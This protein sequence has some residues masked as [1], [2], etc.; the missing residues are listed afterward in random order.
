MVQSY[1]PGKLLLLGM[2]LTLLLCLPSPTPPLVHAQPPTAP[3]V[4]YN[5]VLQTISIGSNSGAPTASQAIDLPTLDATLTGQG[6]PDLIVD[7]GAGV[8]RLNANVVISATARLEV[9]NATLTE[10]RLDSPPTTAYTIIA[11]RGGHLLLDGIT[12]AAW[13]GDAPDDNITNQ[14]SYLVA[15]EGGRI[16]ILNSDVGYLGWKAGEASG[17]SWRKRLNFNDITTGATG[18]IENSTIHHNYFGMYSYEAYGIKILNSTFRDNISYGIDPHD[19]SYEFEVAHNEVYNNGNHGIIFSRLCERNII[20]HNRVHDNA[21]HGIMLDRGSNNNQIYE[22][23]VYNNGDGIAIFQS[24]NNIIRYNILRNNRR[25]IRINATFDVDD[26]Y[27]GI[28]T[29]NEF[30]NNI[31]ENSQE[32]GVY[33][34]ARADRN[35]I[36]DNWIVGSGVNGI[37]IKSGGNLIQN[38]QI[39][40]GTVGINIRGGEYLDLPPQAAP[41][42]DPPGDN[43]VVISTTIASNS[44]TGIRIS[45][46]KNNRIGSTDASV[47]AN[48]IE[49]NGTDGIVIN[50]VISGTQITTATDN[51]IL[52]NII[53]QN[54][55]HGVSVKAASSARNRISQNSITG[56]GQAGIRLDTDAQGG[57]QP[58]VISAIQANG[59]ASGTAQPN[60]TVELYSDPAGEGETYYGAAIA[61]GSGQ[62]SFTLPGDAVPARVTA[63]AIDGNGNTSEFSGSPVNAAYVIG[64]DIH[65][66]TTITVTNSGAIVTLPM[67]Q[68]GIEPTRTGLLADLGGGVWLLNANLFIDTGVTLNIGPASGVNELR[69]RS[70]ALVH[71]AG[72]LALQAITEP[73][74]TQQVLAIDYGSFV[75]LITHNGTIN[76]EGVKIYSWDPAADTFDTDVSNGRAYILAKYAAVLNIRNSDIGYLGSADG[77]SYG[78]SWRDVNALN[79]PSGTH[80]TRVTGEVI[81][82]KI[83]HNYY[84]IYTFQASNMLFQGNEFYQNIR[85]GFDPHDYTHDVWVE[86]NVAYGN[87]SHGFIISRGCNNF[88]FRNNTS[89]NNFD[90]GTSLAHGFMLDPGS[91]NSDTPQAASY[92]NL[93]ENNVAYGNEGYGI[94]ILGS[95]NNEVRN[96]HFYQNQQGIVVD[97]GSP[98]NLISQNTLDQNTAYGLVLRETADRTTVT[99]NII[100]DNK[101]HGIYVR[102]VNNLITGN[103]VNANLAAG[104]AVAINTGIT[105]SIP[106]AMDNQ[107]LSNTISSNAINGL[108]LRGALRTL[109]QGNQIELNQGAGVYVANSSKQ[110]SLVGNTIHGNKNYG[111]WASGGQTLGNSWS[112]NQIFDNLPAGISLT[113]GANGNIPAPQLLN[114]TGNTVTGLA[115]PNV[116]VELFA[117][118][119]TQGRF[120]LGRTA[121]AVDGTFAFTLT[122]PF[123]APNV[124]ALAINADGNAF[125]V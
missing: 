77:E 44:D 108:D 58:P 76:L 67:I 54:G 6:Y 2:L 94:R 102:S 3:T 49:R 99:G 116:T 114:L 22:N 97:V 109:A 125:G 39:L 66:N 59:T 40:S 121:A 79:T 19:Y 110:N 112:E 98:D 38:N 119:G 63:L 55:R 103:T 120:F 75:S 21:L 41:A 7:Q 32:H 8:W 28:S 34:Y 16:D 42:L 123:L 61:N 89:Y 90:P 71:A 101:N 106:M 100:L 84:G 5:P 26:R 20:H 4:T 43:N 107:I 64:P 80:R 92:D 56:N 30:R 24:S 91:P 23:L 14:R 69:L 117:D 87:G 124:T 51:Q 18:R 62:W 12:L 25:G 96:N 9:T 47:A 93:L 37:Y 81:N 115:S 1:N 105:Q 53:R 72:T 31:V 11:K 74:G 111:I 118:N 33:L 78:I 46:G 10:L 52:R 82:S 36:A 50:Q 45:G 65:G 104:I 88:T 83:H 86:N 29:G 57:I 70:E 17:L 48:R 113:T 13:E 60:A 27:D 95:T 15:L 85:Y 122:T 35:T 73:D 68:A